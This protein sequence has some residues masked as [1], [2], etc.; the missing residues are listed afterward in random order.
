L[1]LLIALNARTLL[2]DML[3]VDAGTFYSIGA[4]ATKKAPIMYNGVYVGSGSQPDGVYGRAAGA[5]FDALGKTLRSPGPNSSFN[6]GGIVEGEGGVVYPISVLRQNTSVENGKEGTLSRSSS[7][8]EKEPI[9]F[10]D[11]LEHGTRRCVSHPFCSDVQLTRRLVGNPSCAP[12]LT[13]PCPRFVL[14][15]LRF[16]CYGH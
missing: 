9:S 10:E 4:R 7:F 15:R 5:S 2:A 13:R 11:E 3:G 16:A 1:S 8:A 14:L 12:L 6:H